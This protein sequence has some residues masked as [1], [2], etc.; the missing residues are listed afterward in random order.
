MMEKL[1]LENRIHLLKSRNKCNDR[2]VRKLERKL[3]KLKDKE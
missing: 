3:N 2:I 1:K